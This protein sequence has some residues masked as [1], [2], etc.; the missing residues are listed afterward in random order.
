MEAWLV[1]ELLAW[2]MATTKFSHWE[3]A[4]VVE[5]VSARSGRDVTVGCAAAG[6]PAAIPVESV[7][8]TA[9]LVAAWRGR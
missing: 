6:C 7:G 2:P 8:M 3:S 1:A 4:P 5:V 9:R